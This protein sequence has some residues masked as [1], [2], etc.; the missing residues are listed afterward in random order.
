TIDLT[1]LSL[2]RLAS[3]ATTATAPHPLLGVWESRSADAAKRYRITFNADGTGSIRRATD[4]DTLKTPPRAPVS[5]PFRWYI[6]QNSR[7]GVISAKTYAWAISGSG[8]EEALTLIGQD[9]K[10]R[11][12]YRR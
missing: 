1:G 3:P 2:R 10:A 6:G 4:D 12:L 7:Q 5:D 11:V 8:K 9:G